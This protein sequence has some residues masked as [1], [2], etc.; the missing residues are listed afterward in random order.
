MSHVMKAT[1]TE[2]EKT[3]EATGSV[4]KTAELLGMCG[5]GVHERLRKM[6]LINKLRV[7]SESEKAKIRELYSSGIMRGDGKLRDLSK[8]INRTVPFI[9]RYARSVGLTS[10]NRRVSEE[11]KSRM[12]EIT[13]ATW[14]VKPH[15]KG[16]LGKKHSQESLLAMSA[17]SVRNQAAMSPEKKRATTMKMLKTKS[18]NGTLMMPRKASWKSGWRD[19]GGQRIFARSRWEANYA[20]YLQLLVVGKVIVS[21]EHEPDT[22]WFEKIKRGT[23]CYIPDFKVTL[24]DGSVEY[25]E[26]KGW[27][28]SRSVTKLKRMRIYHPSVKVILRDSA[29]YKRN[30]RQLSAVVPGWE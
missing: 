10:Y 20:R 23:R 16:M 13:K 8:M 28:D 15:P 24:N 27:M 2:I 5:Q 29:W 4:W 1:N 17:A 7:L 25:H 18:V 11:V 3:Y 21:W 19:I 9:S 26:V 12:R 22:F 30:M 6:G 14:S